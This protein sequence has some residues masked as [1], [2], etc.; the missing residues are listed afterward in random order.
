MA[1]SKRMN[2]AVEGKGYKDCTLI[3]QEPEAKERFK[4]IVDYERKEVLGEYISV[5]LKNDLEKQQ[6]L[7]K[8]L[9]KKKPDF[10]KL[11]DD[12][13]HAIFKKSGKQMLANCQVVVPKESSFKK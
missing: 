6:E 12:A 13:I 9:D 4:G 3:C 11:F 8:A 10:E 1:N 5:D 7:L 2:K